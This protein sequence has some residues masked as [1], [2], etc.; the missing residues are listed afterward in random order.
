MSK[1]STALAS[2]PK[3]IEEKWIPLLWSV[4]RLVFQLLVLG[5]LLSLVGVNT[6]I[7]YTIFKEF[8]TKALGLDLKTIV[9]V[10]LAFWLFE[11]YGS[12]KKA[13]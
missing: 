6:G 4:I 11:K 3:V 12:K 13:A 1:L 9:V 2:I 10:L 8:F 7:D 5:F